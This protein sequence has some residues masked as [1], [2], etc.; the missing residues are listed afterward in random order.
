MVHCNYITE[1]DL[2]PTR[3]ASQRYSVVPKKGAGS[4]SIK[5]VLIPSELRQLA[6][7]LE[8]HISVR[9]SNNRI[10]MIAGMITLLFEFGIYTFAIVTFN[11]GKR[12]GTDAILEY[13]F[14]NG[15]V[16]TICDRL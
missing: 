6:R 9:N 15:Q 11:V 10:V 13:D 14:C 7:A 1:G 3:Q 4:S 8:N 5:T 2:E 16:K 12:L